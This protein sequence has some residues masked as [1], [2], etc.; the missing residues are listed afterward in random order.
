MKRPTFSESVSDLLQRPEIQKLA[1]KRYHHFLENRL[2]HSI[3]VAKLAYRIARATFADEVV[4][5]RAGVLHDWYEANHPE[6]RNR[7]GAN[8]HHYQISV[9]NAKA[10]GESDEVL[11]AVH[12]HMWPYGRRAPKTREAWIVW[13]ADNVT[14]LTDL[15]KSSKKVA[16]STARETG[17]ILRRPR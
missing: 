17:S 12:V 14:W 6:H 10:L 7:V 4:C 16:K 11:H 3:A 9:V 8:V 1:E 2:E 5:A 15:F 13:L